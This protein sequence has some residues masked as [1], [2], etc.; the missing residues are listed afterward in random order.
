MEIVMSDEFEY[1]MMDGKPVKLPKGMSKDEKLQALQK[2]DP[3]YQQYKEL[4]LDIP[5]VQNI[6]TFPEY[7]KQLRQ[8]KAD[9]E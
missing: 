9:E 5:D 7:K 2:L 6:P 3:D 8:T 4:Y 1:M